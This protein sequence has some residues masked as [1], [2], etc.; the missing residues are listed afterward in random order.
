MSRQ[1]QRI[2][3]RYG[4]H[5]LRGSKRAA[6]GGI[7]GRNLIF[8]SHQRFGKQGTRSE[9]EQI[10][11]GDAASEETAAERLDHRKEGDIGFAEDQEQ[12][13]YTMNEQ[14]RALS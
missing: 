1:Q 3:H 6:A 2:G 11:Q 10:R 7:D 8:D 9:G 12:R 4:S 5:V 14:I 13:Y